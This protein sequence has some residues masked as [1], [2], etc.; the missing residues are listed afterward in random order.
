MERLDG[1][2]AACNVSRETLAMLHTYHDL[3][4]HWQKAV[5]LVAPSTLDNIWERHF[6]DSAQLYQLLPEL[7]ANQPVNLLDLGSGAGFPGLVLAI[8]LRKKNNVFIHL[9]ESNGRKCAFLRDV[10]RKIGI[11]VGIHNSRIESLLL[12]KKISSVQIFTARAL[13]PLPQLL[14]Y[15]QSS[16]DKG[17]QALFLKGRDSAQEMEQAKRKWNFEV[18]CVPSNTCSDGCIVVIKNLKPRAEE[19]TR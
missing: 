9:V 14:E 11:E 18:G 15:V 10:A 3:L 8:L 7:P 16:W 12:A 17:T 13:A 1:F 5:N 19:V 4:L 6:A 2:I